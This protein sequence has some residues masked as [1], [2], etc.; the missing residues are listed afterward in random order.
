MNAILSKPLLPRNK[1]MLGMHL[2]QPGFIIVY[3]DHSINK[4]EQNNLEKQ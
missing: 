3:L 1:F 4:K 2:K